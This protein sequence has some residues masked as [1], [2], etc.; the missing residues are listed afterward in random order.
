[1]IT[2]NIQ[3]M[4]YPNVMWMLICSIAWWGYGILFMY[5]VVGILLFFIKNILLIETTFKSEIKIQHQTLKFWQKCV[6]N[7]NNQ[8]LI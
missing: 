3:F 6:S 2:K 5:R 8:N 7:F 4:N 1:M